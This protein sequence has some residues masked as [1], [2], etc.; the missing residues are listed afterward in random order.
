MLP[1]RAPIIYTVDVRLYIY[2]NGFDPAIVGAAMRDDDLRMR[3]KAQKLGSST[4]AVTV[5]AEWAHSHD[6]SKG[7]ELVIQ[8]D[9]NGSSLLVTPDEPAADGAE[10]VIDADAMSADALSR[11][12]VTQYVL[13]R[14]LVRIEADSALEPAHYDA[15]LDAERRLMGLGVVEESATH[16]TVRCSVAPDDFELPTL[17]GRLGRTEA[18]IR[19]GAVSALVDGDAD[20]AR[21]AR[22]RKPQLEKLFSLFLRLVFTTY[23]NPRLNH[24]V[25]VGT[26]FPLIG[27]RSAAQDVA[28]MADIADGIAA[29]VAERETD[30]LDET[31][32]ADIEAVHEALDTAA[33][34][35]REAVVDPDYD[36]VRDARESLAR[37]DER[38]VGAVDRLET[39][40]P[41]PL[42][43]LHRT[44]LLLQRSARHTRDTLDVATHLAFRDSPD[45]VTRDDV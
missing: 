5:P 30:P 31:A 9:E 4:L 20:A 28:L 2:T 8:R 6:L 23:R 14:G 33:A 24:A 25:G 42:L 44:H 26:G 32:A 40:R 36:R 18:T 11:A 10:T 7:D 29:Q 22:E 16:I 3:R 13:G 21:R 34:E 43:L 15:V 19:S 17:L 27:Y 12:V 1:V 41:E 39:D 38:S 35:V 45:V 37:V